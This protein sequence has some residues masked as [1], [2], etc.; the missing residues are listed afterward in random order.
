M[1]PYIGLCLQSSVYPVTSS[2]LWILEELLIFFQ[3]GLFPVVRINW[4]LPSSLYAE[5]ETRTLSLHFVTFLLDPV[6]HYNIEMIRV[7]VLA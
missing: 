2:F 3:F 4:Q 7:D 6:L 5:L 1:T